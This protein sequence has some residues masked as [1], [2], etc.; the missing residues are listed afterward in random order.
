MELVEIIK[1][2]RGEEQADLLLKNA[3]VV[4]VFS[5]DIYETNVAIAH[6]NLIVTT[7]EN[8]QVVQPA[9]FSEGTTEIVPRTEVQAGR[10]QGFLNVVNEPTTVGD[11]AASLN[12]LGVT[13]RDLSVIFQ[14]LKENGALHAA[15]ELK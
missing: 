4:N 6:G 13:P 12:A 3:R 11:L 15:L 14:M 7:V 5:G 2:A 1:I 8:P 9:P 10:E